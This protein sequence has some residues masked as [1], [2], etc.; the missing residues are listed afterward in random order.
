[1]YKSTPLGE[2]KI[3]GKDKRY[4]VSSLVLVRS[5]TRMILD[6]FYL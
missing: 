1:M 6:S 2:E 4:I 3:R 5:F